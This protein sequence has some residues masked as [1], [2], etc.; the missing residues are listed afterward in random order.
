MAQ[1]GFWD[2]PDSARAATT[3]LSQLKNAVEPI[4]KLHQKVSDGLELLELAGLENDE[5]TLAEIDAELPTFD[6]ELYG[7]RIKAQMTGR[8]DA[9]N[10]F[11]HLQTG[12]GGTDAND[13]AEM[14][15]R[16][17]SRYCERGGI[18]YKLLDVQIGRA[19]CRERV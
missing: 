6:S 2:N 18:D 12:N 15:L 13:F 9:S 5:A 7:I 17:Y 10:C 11:L 14:V 1:P 19:S 4:G 3:E 8:H 16:M